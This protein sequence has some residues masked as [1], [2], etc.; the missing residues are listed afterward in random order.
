MKR[1]SRAHRD[2]QDTKGP[3]IVNALFQV[4]LLHVLL[5]TDYPLGIL[6][7][8]FVGFLDWFFNALS[9]CESKENKVNINDEINYVDRLNKLCSTLRE[10]CKDSSTE[11]IN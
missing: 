9:E 8:P 5:E 2:G 1:I 7:N 4:T 6:N 11:N 3:N 10:L